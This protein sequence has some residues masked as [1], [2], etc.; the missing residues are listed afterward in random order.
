M[1]TC[2]LAWSRTVVD[3]VIAI[4][5]P[6]LM[7]L[8]ALVSSSIRI[9]QLYLEYALIILLDFLKWQLEGQRGLV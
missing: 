6:L 2:A 9:L 8:H 4:R 5:P 7:A 1:V 3:I